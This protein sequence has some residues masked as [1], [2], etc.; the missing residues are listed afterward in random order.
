MKTLA[1]SI[2]LKA[3]K[4]LNCSIPEPQTAAEKQLQQYIIDSLNSKMSIL[5]PF[6][7]NN[8][9]AI[10]LAKNLLRYRTGSKET[11]FVY[12]YGIYRFSNYL[13]T[14]PDQLI[15]NC[16]D[17]DG[18]PNP[19]AI[20]KYNKL[21]DDYVGELQAQ[22]LTPNSVSCLIKGVKAI[23]RCNGIK[24][25]LNYSLPNRVVYKS[26]APTPE[27]LQKILDIADLRE[28]VIIALLA[29]GGFRESTLIKLKYGHVRRDIENGIIPLHI[30]VE[31]E[32]TKG[33]YHDYHTFLGQEAVN[34]LKLYLQLRRKGTDKIPPENIN[35]DSP[36]IKNMH[37][38]W[39]ASIKNKGNLQHRSFAIPRSGLNF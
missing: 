10:A 2:S 33:K 39:S 31:A 7:F 19:K 23:F 1:T 6:V 35:D 13:N 25:E 15:Q 20:A 9:S 12:V 27:E 29:Y 4:K 18:D 26:R 17:Q 24:L 32:I 38:R 16:K 8:Q 3:T 5:L 22:G 37:T 14:Q 21:L 30:H 28:R 11:L 34:Y 36:L